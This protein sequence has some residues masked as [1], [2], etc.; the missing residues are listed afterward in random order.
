MVPLSYIFLPL[1]FIFDRRKESFYDQSKDHCMKIHFKNYS[2]N[3]FY[4]ILL[5]HNKLFNAIS[6]AKN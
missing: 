4:E 1:T 3:E 6:S 2:C 5:K